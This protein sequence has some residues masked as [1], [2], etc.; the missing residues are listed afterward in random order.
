LPAEPGPVFAGNFELTHRR[1]PAHR[2][3]NAMADRR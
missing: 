3:Y 1:V 2:C